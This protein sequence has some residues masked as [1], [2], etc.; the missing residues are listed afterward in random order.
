MIWDTFIIVG[1]VGT[2][3]FLYSEWTLVSDKL[4][5]PGMI[6]GLLKLVRADSGR[7]GVEDQTG[8]KD[9]AFVTAVNS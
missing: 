2:H 4:N 6:A 9:R 7:K 3:C 5:S 1:Y 8:G